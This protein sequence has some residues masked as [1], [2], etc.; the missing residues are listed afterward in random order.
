LVI[1]A[2]IGAFGAATTLHAE[3]DS[4]LDSAVR[5]LGSSSFAERYE[6]GDLL[7]KAGADALPRLRQAAESPSPEIRYRAEQ[8]LQEIERQHLE[9]QISRILSGQD[10]SNELPAWNRYVGTAGK[11]EGARR[12][13]VEMLKACP[14]LITSV[15]S[16]NLQREF[17]IA[18]TDGMNP[19]F[20]RM[21]PQMEELA[22]VLFVMAQPECVPGAFDAGILSQHL[23]SGR[24]REAI[25]NPSMGPPVKSLLIAWIT[26]DGGGP[27]LYRLRVADSYQLPEG[28]PA[29]R[30][31]LR[32]PGNGLEPQMALPFVAKYGSMEDLHD[33]EELLK[34]S[35]EL[36]SSHRDQSK[37]STEVRDL[38]LATLWKLSD[39]DPAE[40]GLVNAFKDGVLNQSSIGFPS[41][42]ARTKA[43]N[44]WKQWRKQHVKAY[45]PADG[46]AV[47][48]GSA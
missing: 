43:I 19:R 1:G 9:G 24:L 8:L 48:G 12:L 31:L 2:L 33:V 3:S 4:P 6:A 32:T 27:P 39:Q 25:Q 20:G 10:L 44:D 47:E 5:R 26:R 13:F 37:F 14:N 22:S 42:D 38:A 23:V 28:L 7:I 45:L 34:D 16:N 36:T 30:E 15:G 46:N 35:Q 29:A 41:A 18:V 40:H 17:N 21:P 11:S